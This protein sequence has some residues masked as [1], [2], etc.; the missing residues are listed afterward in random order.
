MDDGDRDL[1]ARVARAVGLGTTVGLLPATVRLRTRDGSWRDVDV[2]GAAPAGA[3]PAAVYGPGGG[4]GLVLHL[5]DV[6]DRSTSRRELERM[7]YTDYL[8][9]LPNRARF[10]AALTEAST[11]CLL[12]IDLDGFKAVNDV[13]GHD[14]GDRL[15]CEVA[16]ALRGAAREEDVVARLGGDEFAVLVRAGR[17]DAT[18][19][20]ERLVVL[21]DRDHRPTAPDGSA[22]GGLVLPVSGS[23]GV[24][25]L[26][27][28]GD[29]AEAVRRADLALRAAKAA[30]KNCV[31][32]TGEAL[33]GWSTGAPGWPGSC[34]TPLPTEGSRWSCSPSS[35]RTSVA[36]WGWRPWCAGGT[37]RWATSRRRSSSGWPR[38]RVS[39]CRWSAGSWT[40]PPPC[41]PRCSPRGT[42]CSSG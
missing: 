11:G 18:A 39:S 36:W 27:A 37:R 4:S 20:A 5:R 26:R 34:R 40:P 12:L 38:T 13:A 7:A 32:T 29:P 14:A 15:L 8:T 23:V 3:A 24:A 33:D 31:R 1:V 2:T 22:R 28:G 30:G 10:M 16:E 6:T 19:L 42:T 41:S 25:E 21:L 9:G 17:D 35:V